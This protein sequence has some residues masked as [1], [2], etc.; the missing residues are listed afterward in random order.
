MY[1]YEILTLLLIPAFILSVYAQIKVSSTFKKY[2]KINNS[3]GLTGAQITRQILDSEGLTDIRIEQTSGRL[4]D[5]YSPKERVIR[6]SYDVYNSAS[7]SAIGVAAH[8]CGH[9][10]Q[11][12]YKYFPNTIRTAI[13]PIASIGSFAALPLFILGFLFSF[14]PLVTAGIILYS[15]VVL[16]YVVLLPVEFNASSRA[17]AILGNNNYLTPDE[18]NGSTKV[19][20]AAAMT[21]VAS[22]LMALLQLLRLI[23]MSSRK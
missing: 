8:E 21:Y 1:S 17:I 5:H 12:K 20:Q 14:Y 6:L 22:A 7:I 3:K 15:L 11:E 16:F 19:L 4:S 13:V 10:I 18:L 2:S 9:A 23:S